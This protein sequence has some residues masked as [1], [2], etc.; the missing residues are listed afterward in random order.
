MTTV[1][2]GDIYPVSTIEQLFGMLFIMGGLIF[3]SQIMN[4]Y[5]EIIKNYESQIGDPPKKGSE[6]NNWMLLISRF[7]DKGVP[8]ELMKQ[9][10]KTFSDY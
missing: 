9:I 2:Y 7:S 6:L 1:G 8:T 4:D 10:D 3:F 5:I